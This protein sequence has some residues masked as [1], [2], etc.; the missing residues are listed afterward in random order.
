MPKFRPCTDFLIPHHAFESSINKLDSRREVRPVV[1]RSGAL[2]R[3]VFP[4]RKSL[5]IARFQSLNERNVLSVVEIASEVM[6][7]KTHPAVL[8]LSASN[9]KDIHYTPDLA[10]FHKH[11]AV[12]VEVKSYYFL[13]D[14]NTKARFREIT[15]RLNANGIGLMFLL[16][17]D[18]PEKLLN[19][20]QDQLDRRPLIGR[21]RAGLDMNLVNPLSPTSESAEWSSAQRECDLLITRLMNRDLSK[22]LGK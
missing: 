7:F 2:V 22:L 3:G 5:G 20:T 9:S 17:Q 14:A 19:A 6:A 4:S 11:G 8:R 1:T 21:K 10:L 13:S 15:Q 12:L 18:I 16:D